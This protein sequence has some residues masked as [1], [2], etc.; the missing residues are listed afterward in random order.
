MSAEANKRHSSPP[1][2]NTCLTI[3]AALL[4]MLGPFS[5]DTYLPSFPGIEAEF[6]TSRAI[7]SQSMGVYLAAFAVSTLLWGPL[8]DR[9][10][11][12]L[13]I[14]SSLAFY[15]LASIGCALANSIDTFIVM[16]LFQGLAASGGFIA[17][18]A[19]IRD[20]HSAEAA[21]RAMSH[22]MLLFAIAPAVAPM[23]GGWLHEQLGW[24]SV[25]WFLTS[26][27]LLLIILV[28]LIKET[29]SQTLRQSIHPGLV[30]KVYICSLRHKQF[31]KLVLSQAFSFAGLFLFIAGAPS[32]IYDFLGL[33]SNDFSV[34]FVPMVAGLMLGAFI[35]SQLAHRWST[36][37][38]ITLGFSIMLVAV[39]LNLILVNF[40]SAS[41][42]SVISPL[43]IYTIGLSIIMPIITVLTLDCFPHHRGTASSMHGFI[44]MFINASVASIAVPLLH[45]QWLYFVLGQLIF[46]ML[47]LF[48]WQLVKNELKNE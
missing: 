38:I 20:A 15:V 27:G 30:I 11:R 35:S 42:L 41:V 7:L 8:A 34:Q 1:Q 40:L 36:K 43:V 6:V 33:G 32:V 26:F 9:I 37:R 23:L 31:L 39:V 46:L 5:I 44:Q 12:R 14:L 18:R 48:S 4:A 22:V 47:G 13:V 24:R 21:H 2:T 25:F 45:E 19:M 28:T 3:V 29:L 10:G 17:G 16:R